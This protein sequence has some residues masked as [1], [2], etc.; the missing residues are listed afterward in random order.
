M[1]R[2]TLQE[3]AIIEDHEEPIKSNYVTSHLTYNPTDEKEDYGATTSLLDLKS[4]HS[5]PDL[6]DKEGIDEEC[7]EDENGINSD[8]DLSYENDSEEG[9]SDVG[10]VDSSSDEEESFF[11]DSAEQQNVLFRCCGSRSKS[12][13]RSRSREVC[14]FCAPVTTPLVKVYR[15]MKE[16]VLLVN[17]VDDVWDSPVKRDSEYGASL[18]SSARPH[19]SLRRNEVSS[20][21]YTT[22]GP[23]RVSMRHKVVVF[24]WFVVLATA[25]AIERGSFKVMVDRMGPFRMVVGA[26]VVA[27]I[28]AIVMGLF[29]VF[30]YIFSGSVVD[31]SSSLLPLADIGVI[32]VLDTFQ[33]LFAVISGSHVAPILTTILVHFTIPLTSMI[34][35]CVEPGGPCGKHDEDAI[36][37]A[38][39]PARQSSQ[40]L[41]GSSLITLSTLLGLG[42]ALVTL[43]Y[44]EALPSMSVM[45]DRTAWNTI[46]FVLS[47]IPGAI[48]QMYKERAL[49]TFA[50]PVDSNSL[51]GLLSLFSFAFTLAVCPLVY[52]LQGLADAPT[53]PDSVAG[54]NYETWANLYPSKRISN[55]FSDG[56]KCFVGLLDDE[57]QRNGYPGK[58]KCV[59]LKYLSYISP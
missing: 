26:E 57:T 47:C 38:E 25:F 21:T 15:F 58:F 27:A 16:A 40:Q 9:S 8:E 41:F 50:Q 1:L 48:S 37:S 36:S 42:P 20:L 31:K 34:T 30:R 2:L 55:N 17:N 39:V 53:Q 33:N 59:Q 29:I 54:I 32:A 45:A 4:S 22:N 24:F 10:W 43:I 14:S 28:H 49:M 56:L 12:K 23:T 52:C 35:S 19:S 51:N 5:C 6:M 11:L 46:L 13:K 44:P 3:N 18:S 7:N